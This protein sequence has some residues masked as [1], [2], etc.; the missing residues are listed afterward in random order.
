MRVYLVESTEYRE[1]I[2]ELKV[3]IRRTSGQE[4]RDLQK[5]L[6]MFSEKRDRTERTIVA[7]YE[8]YS[9]LDAETSEDE[10][11]DA[12]EIPDNPDDEMAPSLVN[13]EDED[14]AE[15]ELRHIPVSVRSGGGGFADSVSD[16]PALVT[17]APGI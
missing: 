6:A 1:K 11:M 9:D 12:I 16:R 2:E 8:H 17:A 4:R 5:M 3:R 10:E 7:L 14:E 15:P 13:S